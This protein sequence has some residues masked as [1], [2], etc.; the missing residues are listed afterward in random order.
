MSKL[1]VLIAE[2]SK[3]VQFFYEK[4]LSKTMFEIQI[5]PDGEKA[6]EAY[7]SWK[8]DIVLLDLNMPIMNG[9]QVLKAIREDK[10][11]KT[12]T[13]IMVTSTS[14]KNEVVACAKLGIKG[15]IVKPFKK[16]V[17]PIQIIKCH[18]SS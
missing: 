18:K 11:D 4:E 13:V 10:C 16:N 7:E 14:D 15:Y 1:K 2:D 5:A 8:P 9:Y 6:L 3:L 17:L 12:T